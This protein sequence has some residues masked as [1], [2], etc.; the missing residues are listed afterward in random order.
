MTRRVVRDGGTTACETLSFTRWRRCG[1]AFVLEVWVGEEARQ[2]RN[3]Y[4][5]ASRSGASFVASARSERISGDEER[6]RGG[7]GDPKRR[8]EDDG[9]YTR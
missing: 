5:T 6:N 2:R 8:R 1:A 3:G 4:E 9:A 7:D